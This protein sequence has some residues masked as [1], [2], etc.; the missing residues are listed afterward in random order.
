MPLCRCV[1][2][3]ERKT[4]MILFLTSSPTGAYRSNK[5][6]EFEGFDPANG[7]VEELKRYWRPQSRCLLIAA[8]PDAFSE[9]DVMRDYFEGVLKDTGLSAVCLD[10][11]DG[12]NGKEMAEK[13]RSYDMIILGGGHVP[14]ENAFFMEIGLPQ[15]IRDFDGIVMGISAGTMNCAELVYAQPE[16]PG[17]AVSE[18]YRKF[19][20][21]LGLTKVNILP[22]YQ[23]VKDDYVDGKRL[24]EDITFQDSM[25]HTFYAIVDG[26]YLL[27]TEQGAEIRGEAYRISDGKMTRISSVG[28]VYR[29]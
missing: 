18:T 9:N 11:C 22:H 12:R 28:D 27:Q 13:L 17:E 19:I 15:Q 2:S 10:L 24:F 4:K 16:M 23:A 6:P 20:P 21:G 25:G 3:A 29:L 26:T 14:T 5:P 7:M 1:I 8:F